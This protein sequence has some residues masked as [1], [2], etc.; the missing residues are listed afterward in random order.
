M[1]PLPG[2]PPDPRQVLVDVGFAS[3]PGPWVATVAVGLLLAWLGRR[4]TLP[5]VAGLTVAL[6]APALWYLPTLWWG[7]FPTIDKAG[8]LLFY[9]DGVHRR[10]LDPDDP[11]LRLIGV[12]VGHLWIVAALDLVLEPFAAYNAQSLANL[13][14]SWAAAAWM[15]GKLVKD[16][17]VALLLAFPFG[18]NLHQFRDIN[19]YTVEKTSLYWLP[20]YVGCLLDAGRA[21]PAWA[22]RWFALREPLVLAGAFFV[23]VY[24]G[25]LCAGA[26]AF[27]FLWGPRERRWAVVRSA[28]G[29]VPLVLYQWRLMTGA[30]SLGSPEQF[31]TE[32]A[33]L[34]VFSLS[35]PAWNR[36]EA[37][38]VL[39]LPALALALFGARLPAAR[40]WLLLAAASFVLAL[41]PTGNPVYLLL[42]EVVPGFWRVAKPE[43]FF[44]VTWL[45][46]LAAAALSLDA[47]RPAPRALLALA[48]AFAAG[49]IASART[50]AVYPQ[51]T[52]PVVVHLADGWQRAV[53]RGDN[54]E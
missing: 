19:W 26:G 40:P 47:L 2:P 31:L 27:L 41:G 54:P 18:M 16:R 29:P 46:L 8:S 15:F 45:G 52:L 38:R 7:S 33:A 32:R 9:Q 13:A 14:L 28:L 6:T 24:V 51:F 12:H 11:A 53:P 5:L 48:A 42:F 43:S 1:E 10:F 50:H 17:R 4:R 35:P 20:L 25:L 39:N 3:A 36:I 37:W 30:G 23:N 22:G 49:W 44:H 21:P 34:D